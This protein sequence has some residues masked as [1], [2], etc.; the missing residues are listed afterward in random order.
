M[1]KIH[2]VM[3]VFSTL[4][5]TLSGCSKTRNLEKVSGIKDE[6]IADSVV[7]NTV[8]NIGT[9]GIIPNPFGLI[10]LDN[11]WSIHEVKTSDVDLIKNPSGFIQFQSPNNTEGCLGSSNEKLITGNCS[12]LG[13]DSFFTLIPST[14]GA[15]QIKSVVSQKCIVRGQSI[16][17]FHMGSCVE[18]LQRTYLIVPTG[19][20][21]VIGPPVAPAK[22]SPSIPKI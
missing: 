3:I 14:T 13:K 2:Y 6:S 21:W 12:T 1:N 18:D 22:I 8:R 4:I 7:M 20:L 11:M 10:D 16:V 15:V 19:N 9:G 5:L 17:D